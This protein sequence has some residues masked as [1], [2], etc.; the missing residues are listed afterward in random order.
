MLDSITDWTEV[1]LQLSMILD[2]YTLLHLCAFTMYYDDTGDEN[3]MCDFVNFTPKSHECIKLLLS[4]REVVKSINFNER[5][6]LGATVLHYLAM[7][8]NSLDVFETV[9]GFGGDICVKDKELNSVV[10]YAIKHKNVSAA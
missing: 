7:I 8:P 10:H 2:S 3:S 1:N 5:D 9:V 4:N 6:R